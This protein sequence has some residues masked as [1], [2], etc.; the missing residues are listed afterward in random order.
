MLQCMYC[1]SEFDEDCASYDINTVQYGMTQL[2]ENKQ[3]VCPYCG[4]ADLQKV[5][6][7]T[8]GGE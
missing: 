7:N 6:A 5:D 2:L 4:S 8:R 3:K 1:L